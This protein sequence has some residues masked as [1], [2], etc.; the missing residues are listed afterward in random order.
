MGAS[1]GGH[2]VLRQ[3]SLGTRPT[4]G[5]SKLPRLS[6]LPS[7]RHPGRPEERASAASRARGRPDLIKRR[8]TRGHRRQSD[9]G[10][11]QHQPAGRSEVPR[12]PPSGIEP[13]SGIGPATT[14]TYNYMRQTSPWPHLTGSAGEGSHRSAGNSGRG[15]GYCS[16][17]E[18]GENESAV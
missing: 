15:S 7:P 4:A 18:E 10:K 14:Y 12:W 11:L 6:P 9:A 3:A 1:T 2:P 13:N 17:R 16:E 5:S 8:G